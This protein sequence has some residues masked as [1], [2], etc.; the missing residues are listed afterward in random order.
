MIRVERF[1]VA[2]FES[3]SAAGFRRRQHRLGIVDTQ[4]LSGAEV[5]VEHPS[6]LAG[7]ATEIDDAHP[8]PAFDQSDEIK[9]RLLSFVFES[10][11]LIGTPPRRLHSTIPCRRM[12][13]ISFTTSVVF[14]PYGS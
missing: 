9:K 11:V 6:Q 7:A 3:H 13:A 2:A 5:L 14:L 8:R 12:S 4:R 1:D 10:L